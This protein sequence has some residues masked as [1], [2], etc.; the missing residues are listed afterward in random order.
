[1]YVWIAFLRHHTQ[2]LYT[3]Q[4][5]LAFGPPSLMNIAKVSLNCFMLRN[6]YHPTGLFAPPP[7]GEA[8]YT[9]VK[10]PYSK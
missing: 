9:G 7:S 8:A 5:G 2:D 4:N 1:L 10:N 3:Y 6:I